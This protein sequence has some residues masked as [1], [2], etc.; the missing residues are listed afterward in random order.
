[1][2]VLRWLHRTVRVRPLACPADDS[3]PLWKYVHWRM[4]YDRDPRLI[5]FED[6]LAVKDL[7]RRAGVPSVPV[8][9]ELDPSLFDPECAGA[10]QLPR[11][12]LKTNHGYADIVFVERLERGGCRLGGRYLRGEFEHWEDGRRLLRAHFAERLRLVHADAEWAVTRI[13]PRRL[14]AEPW[15]SLQ[16]DYKVWVVKG[17]AV[18]IFA[19]ADRWSA[20]GLMQGAFDREWRFLGAS[21]STID[22]HGDAAADRVCARFP[23]PPGL[24]RLIRHAEDLVP[25]DMGFMRAD[26]YPTEGD[27]FVLGECTSYPAG[28][29][30]VFAPATERLLG[31]MIHQRWRK[32][33]EVP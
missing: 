16:D 22:L 30:P 26:F 20:Q 2:K 15:L 4:W 11:F 31:R 32:A 17:R 19:Y 7:A 27:G 14:F 5:A 28:G 21:A 1:V 9:A 3:W 8:L 12:V 6:K 25:P 29:Y 10:L 13:T 24:E 18:F 33:G 23:R